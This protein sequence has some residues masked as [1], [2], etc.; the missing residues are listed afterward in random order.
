MKPTNVTAN[1]GKKVWW[2]C[3]NGHEWK[4]VI[5]H[6]NYGGGCPICSG[7]KVLI[8]YNDLATVN[9]VLAVQW[10][11]NKNGDIKPTGVTA[12]SKKKVWWICEKG[13]EW[14]AI[15]GDRTRGQN[16][17]ICA[18]KRIQI[19]FND[20]E[21]VFPQLAK[22]WHPTKNGE[23]LP[24]GVTVGSKKKVWWLCSACGHEWEAVIHT[25]SAGHGCPKCAKQ[26]MTGRKKKSS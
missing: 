23:L 8:G 14:E 13:H 5:A 10:H 1:S 18:N 15:I 21:T 25:R 12:N 2:L 4:G 17:P 7:R 24:S 11:Q 20:L 3:E 6:R 26:K 22:E 19:G 16:C 9:P